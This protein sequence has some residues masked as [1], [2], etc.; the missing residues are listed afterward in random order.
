MTLGAPQP[1][2]HGDPPPGASAVSLGQIGGRPAELVVAA[3]LF[4]GAAIYLI[5]DVLLKLG[6]VFDIFD[7]DGGTRPG[8]F[9]LFHIITYV[10]VSV[11]LLAT[12]WLLVNADPR[13]RIVAVVLA[14]SWALGMIAAKY[15]FFVP[16]FFSDNGTALSL[17]LGLIAVLL[18]AALTFLPGAHRAFAQHPAAGTAGMS[19]ARLTYFGAALLIL[20]QGVFL[21]ILSVGEA[22]KETAS[23]IVLI[24][25]ALA[26][27]ALAQ[28]LSPG[29]MD[30]RLALSALGLAV[31]ITGLIL[32]P[33]F[34]LSV[35]LLSALL[36]LP[37]VLW[38]VSDARTFFGERP[39]ALN[40]SGAFGSAGGA[41]SGDTTRMAAVGRPA[42][43]AVTQACSTCGAAL[44][45]GDAFCSSCGTAAPPP[46]SPAAER[47]CPS[48][49]RVADADAAFCGGCGTKLG[50][51]AAPAG[52][53]VC[54][55]C[56]TELDPDARF[57]GTCGTP[58]GGAQ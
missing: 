40:L 11:G 43:A 44:E 30:L 16:D 2:T 55:T 52:P 51:A 26:A 14:L 24:V 29:R 48:C 35:F 58:V 4:A 20:I 17:T 49:G 37:F 28:M 39:L 50:D 8:L 47:A 15:R 10:L 19:A 13:G 33:R 36:F 41:T 1:T 21:L 5:I 57:C 6:D 25:A 9:Y 27:G 23:G 38:L 45:P 32:G 53:P 34:F 22:G 7:A 46:A 42:P 3:V 12:A 56:N 54:A 18:G 31:F